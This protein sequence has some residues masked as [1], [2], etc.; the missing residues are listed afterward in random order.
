[1]AKRESRRSFYAGYDKNRYWEKKEP[2]I[3]D[4][5]DNGYYTVGEWISYYLRVNKLK[6]INLSRRAGIPSQRI[7]EYISGKRRI[8]IT[9]SIAME[10]ALD[11]H[12]YK[13]PGFFY[14]MQTMHDIFMCQYPDLRP[15]DTTTN[16]LIPCTIR[17]L[18]KN[19]VEFKPDLLL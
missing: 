17:I 19:L 18:K 13:N 4:K 6:P 16:T 1:M 15:V 3:K 10:K 7:Y 11:M 14:K 9:T 12:H 5:R 8:S 2:E